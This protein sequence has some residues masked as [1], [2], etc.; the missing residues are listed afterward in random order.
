MAIIAMNSASEASA[1]ASW[2]KSAVSA[3]CAVVDRQNVFSALATTAL[4]NL[5]YEQN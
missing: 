2:G 3:V 4:N 5:A 1:A